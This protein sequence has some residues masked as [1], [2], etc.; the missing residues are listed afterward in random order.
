MNDYKEGMGD[1]DFFPSAIIYLSICK[2]NV[3]PFTSPYLF[4]NPVSMS[5][6]PALST[7]FYA[8]TFLGFSFISFSL[9]F[10]ITQSD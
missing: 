6:S 8:C 10:N 3:Y 1:T 5:I 4:S 9:L 7:F 2:E